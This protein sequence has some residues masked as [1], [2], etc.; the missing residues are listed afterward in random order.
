MSPP[1][2]QNQKFVGESITFKRLFQPWEKLLFFFNFFFK[3]SYILMGWI[4]G[5]REDQRDFTSPT[6]MAMLVKDKIIM[7]YLT[8]SS[9]LIGSL[10]QKVEE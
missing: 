3:M 7:L 6:T 4:E 8:S 1:A 2:N 9:H 5:I 10:G